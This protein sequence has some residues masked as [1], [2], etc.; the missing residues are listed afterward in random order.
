M[1]TE[2]V[3][4]DVYFRMS[5]KE[6]QRYNKLWARVYSYSDSVPHAWPLLLELQA[7]RDSVSSKL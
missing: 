7:M 5:E 3:D 2:S 6:Q 1:K 4:V